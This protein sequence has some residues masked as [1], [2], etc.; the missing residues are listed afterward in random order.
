MT[1]A[2]ERG[3]VAYFM[4][5]RYFC[6]V[7]LI[8]LAAALWLFRSH[9][10]SLLSLLCFFSAVETA[11][12][13]FFEA[14]FPG[15]FTWFAV[16]YIG[17]F[18]VYPTFAPLI[19]IEIPASAQVF[20]EYCFLAVAGIHLF[21]LGYECGLGPAASRQWHRQY[22]TTHT[23]LLN[24]VILLFFVNLIAMAVVLAD[25]GSI[26]VLLRQTRDEMKYAAG[27]LNLVAIYL[28]AIGCLM[29][30]LL[31][32]YLRFRRFHIVFWL[33]VIVGIE[34]FLFLE[35]RVRTFPV[36]HFVGLL[37]GWFLIA[38]RMAIDLRQPRKRQRAGLTVVQKAGLVTLAVALVLGMFVLR[39]F[40]GAYEY[41]D[42]LSDISVDISSSVR[43]AF[44]G[45]GEIGYSKW[46]FEALELVPESYGYLHGQSYYRLL[47]VP[48]PRSLWPNKPLDTQRI[49][50]QWINPA[51]PSIQTTPVGIFGDLYIN[52]G[53]LGIFGMALFGYFF[54]RLDRG[55]DLKHALFLSVSF[56]MVFHFT[57]GAFT[58]PVMEMI[59]AFTAAGVIGNYLCRLSKSVCSSSSAKSAVKLSATSGKNTSG[60]VDM[61]PLEHLPSELRV[62]SVLPVLGHPRDS[63]RIA[64]LQ[65]AGFSVEA[66]AFERDYHAGRMPLCP[67]E[68][69]GKIT[70]GHYVQRLRKLLK[71]VPAVRRALRRN[72]VAYASGPDMAL[73]ALIAGWGL[74]RPIVLEVGDVR[75]VQVAPGWKGRVARFLDKRFVEKCSLLVATAPGFI[76]DYY[77]KWL[78]A[79]VPAIVIENK[80]EPFSSDGACLSEN[81]AAS[82][83]GKPLLERPLRIGYFGGLRCAWSWRVLEGLAKARPNDVEIV[84]AGYP[85]NPVD[86]PQRVEHYNNMKYLGQ[87]QSPQDLPMLYNAVDIIWACYQPIGAADW[88]LRWARPNRFYESCFFKKPLISRAGSS[89]AVVVVKHDLGLIVND[90]EVEQAVETLSRIT[91]ADLDRWR[92]NIAVLP[93]SFYLYTTETA[94]L[95]KAIQNLVGGACL[96]MPL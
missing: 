45:G 93:E 48:I 94:D 91:R 1:A 68:T 4:L 58:N 9:E 38:P 78:G 83:E 46:V 26:S 89:D 22:K 33:P 47:F 73:V 29:Y 14:K 65:E 60:D 28:F 95:A 69:L 81:G 16:A 10:L 63:K 57:R 3:R 67:V 21:I 71:A 30:P 8:W 41:A 44:E 27:S 59:V 6:S 20:S 70:H 36:A 51:A 62:L 92:K 72:H 17:L 64:M 25:A 5:R 31:G 43:F 75:E 77:R 18:L 23:R 82:L 76:D 12:Y 15:L 52:F 87:Y 39:V 55:L 53:M 37:A 80:L 2:I 56:A 84:F 35:F 32:I 19:G 11:R 86:L 61:A 54:G 42:S 66:V 24:A 88:N 34:V 40:R 90:S 49:V 13:A 79:S 50:A 7:S 96:R 85:M 74:G